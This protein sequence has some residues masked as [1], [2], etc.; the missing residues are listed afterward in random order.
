MVLLAAVCMAAGPA[1]AA[2]LQLTAAAEPGPRIEYVLPSGNTDAQVKFIE[3]LRSHQP[4]TRAADALHSRLAPPL[5]R[6]AAE[7]ILRREKDEWSPPYQLAMRVLLEDRIRGISEPSAD[8]VRETI[9]Y[10][11]AF[12][13]EKAKKGL[14][15]ADLE[16]GGALA[17]ALEGIDDRALAAEK[18]ATYAKLAGEGGDE[19]LAARRTLLEAAARRM[20][21]ADKEITL[22]GTTLDGKE[23]DWSAYK[24]KAVLV[25]F[26]DAASER[27]RL[28][29]CHVKTLYGLYHNRGLEVVGVS[30]DQEPQAMQEFA[31]QQQLPWTILRDAAGDPKKR[32][33][34]R[35]GILETPTILLVDKEGKVVAPKGIGDILD[36]QLERVLGPAH[37]PA[38]LLTCLDLREKLNF[39]LAGDFDRMQRSNDLS[40]LPRGEQKLAGVKFT[41]ADRM[42]ALRCPAHPDL[43]TQVEGIAVGKPVARIYILQGV[44]WGT[45]D[46]GTS[47][48]QYRIHYGDGSDVELPVVLGDDARDWWNVDR[49]RP[50][51]RGVVAWAGQNAAS[52]SQNRALRLYVAVWNNPH[53][54]KEVRS[55]DFVR[56]ATGSQMPLCIAI[57]VEEPAKGGA[58]VK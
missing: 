2:Q 7:Q 30:T 38:G 18:C 32:M 27:C 34:V 43:P 5:L 57:S 54:E 23:F 25:G 29:Q 3:K 8:G 51:T 28:E 22:E 37:E 24:G 44:Q 39:A 47:V 19:K 58:R 9:E 55:I 48:A 45:G 50:V 10:V 16:L 52:R 6:Q 35:C 36:R 53:P 12:L 17:S 1:R 4:K 26:W 15:P 11:D 42:V 31:Q 21:L 40:E 14:E 46:D 13:T 33:T 41:I 49:H 20:A 56:T